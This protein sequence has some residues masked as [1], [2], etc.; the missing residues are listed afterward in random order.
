[1]QTRT[2]C[3]CMDCVTSMTWMWRKSLSACTRI[4]ASVHSVVMLS[5]PMHEWACN[6]NAC[7][8]RHLPIIRCLT[9]GW[10]KLTR[11]AAAA[12][13]D[14]RPTTSHSMHVY[15]SMHMHASSACQVSTVR[16]VALCIRSD[17]QQYHHQTRQSCSPT[18]FHENCPVQAPGKAL[19]CAC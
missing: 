3:I 12:Q 5:L 1:M 18:T 10:W 13:H 16:R 14:Y 8:S 17:H 7:M 19:Q 6:W 15:H 11:V 4:V 2:S 9:P